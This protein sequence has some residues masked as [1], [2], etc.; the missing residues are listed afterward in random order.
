MFYLNHVCINVYNLRIYNII[1][2]KKNKNK[3]KI[4]QQ[5]PNANGVTPLSQTPSSEK[6]DKEEII[7]ALMAND[8]VIV[9]TCVV[10][11]HWKKFDAKIVELIVDLMKL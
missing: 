1:I 3:S 11:E 10:M 9:D 6:F 5:R 7:F 8:K 4:N 2:Y